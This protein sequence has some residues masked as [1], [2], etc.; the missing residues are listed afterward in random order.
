[1]TPLSLHVFL[2][3]FLFFTAFAACLPFAAMAQP[4]RAGSSILD[5]T[6]RNVYGPTTSMWTTE[7]DLF[8]NRPNYK[9]LDTALTNYHRWTYTQRFNY[10]YQDLGV[11]GTAMNSIFP[12]AP[13]TIGAN[14]GFTAYQLY[15]TTDEPVYFDTHSPFTK[16]KLIWGGQGRAT[17]KIEFSRNINPRWNFGFNYRPILIDKQPQYQKNTPQTISHYYDFD[18][19]Y[20]SKNEKYFLLFNFRRLRHRVN[21]QGELQFPEGSSLWSQNAA[22]ALSVA[23][24][25]EYRRNIHLLNQYQLAQP[26]QIY[27]IL[28]FT[29]QF[30][31]FRD[32]STKDSYRL[33]DHAELDSSHI[34]DAVTL[35]SVQNEVGIKGNVGKLFYAGHVKLRTYSYESTYLTKGAGLETYF[36]GQ[37]SLAFDS[38]TQISGSVEYLLPNYYRIEGRI[39]SPWLEGYFV[40]SL[41]KPGLMQQIYRGSHDLWVNQFN[42]ISTT[43][44]QGFLKF[45]VNTF[46]F[47]GGATFNLLHNTVY[48]KEADP[49]PASHNQ[50][51]LPYQSSGFQSNIS[52][53]VKMSVSVFKHVFIRP[54]VIYTIKPS[55]DDNVLQIPDFF[56]NLQIAYENH[57]F[58]NHLQLQAGIDVHYQSG[59]TPLAYDPAIQQFYVQREDKAIVNP[60]FPV[61]DI[62]VNGK[63]R[64]ARLF[65][66]YNNLVQAVTKGGYIPTPGFPGQMNLID[67]GFEFLLFD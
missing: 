36:G 9:P 6:T 54:Q 30:N 45:N 14:S 18:T 28:D 26:L 27:H 34:T 22:P 35:N 3:K 64:R 40:N 8:A 61:T 5:D 49:L 39:Q 20:R 41:S 32:D 23:Q 44:A 19:T 53:E 4:G 46:Q 12:I 66:K 31:I 29:K 37:M 65:F 63:M 48:F 59:Y 1:M 57:L 62:F 2:R 21:E 42:G 67:F 33:F 10:M 15:W 56:A 13:S 60:A 58:N 25:E 55:N 43:Q 51:V 50:K 24:T 38:V 16:M 17:T 11:M 7:Q 47:W 52:P